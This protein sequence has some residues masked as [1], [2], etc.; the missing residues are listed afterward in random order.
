MGARQDSPTASSSRRHTIRPMT[1]GSNTIRQTADQRNPSS[2]AGSRRRA[3]EFLEHGLS[4]VKRISFEKALRAST[5]H[6]HD[7][8]NAYIADLAERARHGRHSWR[9]DQHGGR[10]ARWRRRPLLGADCRALRVEP[11]GR[12]RGRRSDLPFHDGRLGRPDPHGSI[13]ALC[14]AAIDRHEGSLRHRLR[15]RH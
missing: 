2:P 1:A 8:L 3:N 10:S 5:T 13:L 11:H 15:L 14:D 6:R 9:E 7:Y 4:G 12:Q